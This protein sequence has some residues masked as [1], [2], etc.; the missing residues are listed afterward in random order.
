MLQI[1][2]ENIN[3]FERYLVE[4]EKSIATRKKYLYDVRRFAAFAEKNQIDKILILQYKAALE[5]RYRISSVNSMLAALNSFLRY[6]GYTELCVRQ[7]RVQKSVYCPEER[8]LTK[9]EYIRLV[10]TAMESGNERLALIFQTICGT[11]IRVSELPFVTV[12]AA[13]SG[14]AVAI[15]KGKQRR[16]FLVDALCGK[17]LDYARRQRI[18]SGSVFVTRSAMPIDRCNIWREMKTVCEKAGVP[19][20][21]VYP[22]NLRHLFARTFYEMEKDIV[23]L[24]DVLGHSNVNTTRIY[25]ISSGREHRRQVENMQLVL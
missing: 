15:C 5:T 23:K 19:Q 12:E 4:T 24:A 6:V 21:K 7:I 14:E 1:T 10:R 13:Q 25:T 9:G 16:V 17:L 18:A 11:G 8:E 3:A 22:H 2:T 20:E